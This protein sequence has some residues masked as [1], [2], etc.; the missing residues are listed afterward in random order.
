MPRREMVLNAVVIWSSALMYLTATAWTRF[1]ASEM[2]LVGL[3]ELTDP[4]IGGPLTLITLVLAVFLSIPPL[5]THE[6]LH[7]CA[8]FC[9]C[10]ALIVGL[11]V[12]SSAVW[13]FTIIAV[14]ILRASRPSKVDRDP[15]SKD[16]SLGTSG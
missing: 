7:V 13:A 16:R 6:R 5:W 1:F 4:A 3:K 8:G 11:Y 10:L 9:L 14:N 15:S 12:V 2:P